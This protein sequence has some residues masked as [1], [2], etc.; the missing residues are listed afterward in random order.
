MI[1][2]KELEKSLSFD[3]Y[4]DLIENLVEKGGTTGEQSQSN[5]DYTKLNYS[6]MKRLLKTIQLTDSFKERVISI[7]HQMTWIILS[8]S[9]CGDAAQNLPVLHKM[10]EYKDNI[11]IRILLRDEN[12]DVMDRYLTN[13]GRSIPKLIAIG[14]NEQELFTW[15]PRPAYLQD[16]LKREKE[17]PTMSTDDLKKEFQLW[18]TKDKGHTLQQ[19]VSEL[20]EKK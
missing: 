16:W 14:T 10:A 6:R 12:L 11:T 19:E 1:T 18:Y 3:N 2:Q 15:G 5:I 8:E 4:L 13:G 17:N 7:S 20:L 9:W